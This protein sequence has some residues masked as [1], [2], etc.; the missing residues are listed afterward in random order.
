MGG[1][2][3]EQDSF[4]RVSGYVEQFDIHSPSTTVFEALTFS[5]W[6]RLSKD[7]DP[8]TRKVRASALLKRARGRA[9]D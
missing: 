6:L 2:P 4:A 9:F 3:K 5:A 8:Q 1:F 7:V